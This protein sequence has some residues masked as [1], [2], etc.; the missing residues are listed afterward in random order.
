MG[1]NLNPQNEGKDVCLPE[2][3]AKVCVPIESSQDK[4][5]GSHVVL[6]RDQH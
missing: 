6:T 2:A 4:H 3:A 5:N 1:H